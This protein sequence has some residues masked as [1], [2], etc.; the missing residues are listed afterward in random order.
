MVSFPQELTLFLASPNDLGGERARSRKVAERVNQSCGVNVGFRIRVTGWEDVP[1]GLGRPQELINPLVDQCDIFIAL[2]NRRWGSDSGE[3]SSGFEEEFERAVARARGGDSAPAIALFFKR[4]PAADED[5]AGPQLARLLEFRRRIQDEHVALYRE[6][7]SL[8]DLDRQLTDYLVSLITR[9]VASA[10]TIEGPS[11]PAPGPPDVQVEIRS[12][13]PSDDSGLDDAQRQLAAVLAAYDELI[14]RGKLTPGL[15]GDRLMLFALAVRGEGIL[16]THVA[17]RLYLRRAQV[18]LVSGE[19]GQWMR[20]LAADMAGDREADMVVPGWYFVDE[21]ILLT[22]LEALFHDDDRTVSNGA[23][24]ILKRLG[25]RPDY[26][27]APPEASREDIN[28]SA[29]A[30]RPLLSDF[31]VSRT[32]FAYL[33]QV[34][35]VSDVL[36]LE[37]LSGEG[38]D[39]LW[40][41]EIRA[42]RDALQGEFDK[43]VL[44]CTANRSDGVRWAANS[45]LDQ[46][47]SL[48]E[49][50]LVSLVNDGGGD[51]NLELRRA[52]FRRL[53]SRGEIGISSLHAAIASDDVPLQDLGL[54][55]LEGRDDRQAVATE[56]WSLLRAQHVTS[57]VIPRVTALALT[58][59]ELRTAARSPLREDEWE[60]L[61]WADGTAMASEARELLRMGPAGWARSA[62]E[63]EPSLSD[64]EDLLRYLYGRR[65]RAAVL[66]LARL[67]VDAQD[68]GDVGLVRKELERADVTT[69]EDAASALATIGLPEDAPAI[70]A[71]AGVALGVSR[72]VLV[73]TALSLGGLPFARSQIDNPDPRIAAAAARLVTRDEAVEV[74]ELEQLLNH[75]QSEVRLAGVAE[76]TKRLTRQQS[77]DLLQ[78]YPQQGH[79]YYN[80]VAA[81]DR[82]LY[83]PDAIV[84]LVAS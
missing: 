24:M 53:A 61:L 83:A 68:A 6:F 75:R 82:R 7:E 47:G 45:L 64:H 1:P 36:L 15:D 23:A 13:E 16:P 84:R 51:V 43:I 3:A 42:L 32:F 55:Y 21:T 4:L 22:R 52:A 73:N 58:H 41:D 39:H 65:A 28:K 11:R 70:V 2:L 71:A 72:E 60:A 33:A 54:Q 19:A 56:L 46:L 76:L 48:S 26:L 29:E 78:R 50:N 12:E 20:A 35:T 63:D 38:V 8:D 31:T 66:L 30:W 9:R 80:V 79:Y 40:T 49:A 44:L 81:L 5:D 37:A 18:H 14:R 10:P 17:N 69:R 25:A 77:E 57:N 62:L 59:E 67:P 74:T 27:W 34:S